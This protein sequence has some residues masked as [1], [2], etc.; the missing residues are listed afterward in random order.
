MTDTLHFGILS[1]LDYEVPEPRPL[2]PAF[3]CDGDSFINW[4]DPGPDGVDRDG[5]LHAIVVI[6][7]TA[8]DHEGQM[9]L[10]ADIGVYREQLERTLQPN[11]RL[12]DYVVIT[13]SEDWSERVRIW[14]IDGSIS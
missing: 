11:E 8:K 3:I 5:T 6:P 7:E 10:R 9:R 14:L 1:T 2:P 12:A 13:D 4:G